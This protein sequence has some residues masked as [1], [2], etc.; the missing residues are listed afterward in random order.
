MTAIWVGLF[1]VDTI[2]SEVPTLGFPQPS[3]A[4]AQQGGPG[5]KKA[6]KS[7]L[8]HGFWMLYQAIQLL[9]VHKEMQQLPV[10]DH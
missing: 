5:N 2:Q 1:K 8:T 4:I 9:S 6:M 10:S 7:S 3:A